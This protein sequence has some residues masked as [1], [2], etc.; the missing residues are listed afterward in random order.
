MQSCNYIYKN[1]T[2]CGKPC[3]SEKCY[4]HNANAIQKRKD[5]YLRNQDKIK[6]KSK[7]NSQTY[8]LQHRD[9]LMEKNKENHKKGRSKLD[10]IIKE[11]IRSSKRLDKINER[12]YDINEEYVTMDWIKEELKNQNNECIYC[13]KEMKLINFE[14]YDPDQFTIDRINNNYAHLKDNCTLSCL[15]CNI[16]HTNT[17]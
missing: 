11:K 3:K 13:L 14:P 5:H 7:L 16:N 15:N 10:M 12:H 4:R 8:Y 2:I 1:K 6:L 17:I 9:Y